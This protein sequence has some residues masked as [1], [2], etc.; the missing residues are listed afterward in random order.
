MKS[1]GDIAFF[2]C[3]YEKKEIRSKT[4]FLFGHFDFKILI[5]NLIDSK[6]KSDPVLN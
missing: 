1:N 3:G 6:L 4:S 2:I 5:F